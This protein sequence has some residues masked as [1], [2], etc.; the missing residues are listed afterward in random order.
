MRTK[1]VAVLAF[2]ILTSVNAQDKKWTLQECINYA[3]DHNI[4]VKQQEL[5]NELIAE[6]ITTAKGNFLPNLN[7]SASQNYNFGTYVDAFNNFVS[8]SSRSNNFGAS[9]NVTVFNGF[10]NKNNL[11]L[12][13]K[14]LEAAGFDLEENKNSIML[15]VVNGYLNILLNKENVIIAQEQIEISKSQVEQ[16][17]GLVE[18]GSQPV[19]YLLDA[20]A[21]LASN[22][23]QLTNA[24]NAL[25]ISTLNL[26][27]L[28]LLPYEGF[29]VVDVSLDVS[30]ASLLYNN[31]EEIFQKSLTFLPEIRSA[32]I[33]VENSELSID[34]AKADYIP[35]LNFGAG[36]GTSYQRTIGEKD[37]VPKIDPDT[38]ETI[39]VANGF[40]KQL[41]DNLGYNFGVTLNIPIFNRYQIKSNISRARI[42]QKQAALNLEDRKIKLRETIENAY[43]DARASLNQFISAEKSLRAQEESFKNAQVSYNSGVMTSFDYDQVRNRLVSAQSSLVNAKYNFVFRTKVLEFYYGLP[44]EIN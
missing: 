36:I 39:L 4:S 29:D 27:Q 32:E 13:K 9:S 3:L 8:I 31:T 11:L 40:S 43:V 18:A 21:T 5:S 25:D 2:I 38:G 26:A 34:I 19:S 7:A 28:L 15:F 41:K 20:E 12:A 6:D 42:N 37:V 17:K 33:A 30:S 35:S 23:E 24:K 22:E 10:K 14:N 16:A 1:L 44:L